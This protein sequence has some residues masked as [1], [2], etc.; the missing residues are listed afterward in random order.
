MTPSLTAMHFGLLP[1]L[2]MNRS[3]NRCP[4]FFPLS[5]QRMETRR[6]FHAGLQIVRLE[7]LAD[8]AIDNRYVSVA[9]EATGTTTYLQTAHFQNV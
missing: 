6:I 4:I 8:F 3:C 9:R 5:V 7:E 1:F 2:S